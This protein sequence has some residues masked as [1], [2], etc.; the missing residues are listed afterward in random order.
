MGRGGIDDPI[1]G[2]IPTK[3]TF[4]ARTQQEAKSKARHFL[5]SAQIHLGILD[6]RLEA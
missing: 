5:K 2:Q 4:K 1:G 3:R 6:V